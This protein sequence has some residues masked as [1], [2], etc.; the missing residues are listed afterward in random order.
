V[1]R[2]QVIIWSAAGTAAI[3][4]VVALHAKDSLDHLL[5]LTFLFVALSPPIYSVCAAHVNDHADANSL[6]ATAGSLVLVYGA[7]SVLGPFVA[8]LLMGQLGPSGI[9]VLAGAIEL[10]FVVYGVYR[11]IQRSAVLKELKQVF[12]PVPQTTHVAAHLDKRGQPPSDKDK[13]PE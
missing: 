1:Y 3:S 6:V 12:V 8:S 11:L 5:P 9:Y 13:A 10:V 2:R 4:F 7:G